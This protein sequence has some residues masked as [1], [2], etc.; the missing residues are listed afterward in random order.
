M[1]VKLSTGYAAST[2][3]G[4]KAFAETFMDG[5]IEVRSGTQP[6]SADEPV[7]G[8]LLARITRDG[9][10][11]VAGSSANGLRWTADGRFVMKDPAHTWVLKGSATGTAGWLRVLPNLAD[12][13]VFSTTAERI[14]GTIDLI[15]A[16]TD[17]Q[18]WLPSLSFTPSTEIVIQQFWY[19]IPPLGE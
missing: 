11:W 12:S 1:S 9:G 15:D 3:L 7:T 6:A 14:D 17:A 19:A 8:T 5:C 2:A 18:L 4:A 16:A 13:G 10:A